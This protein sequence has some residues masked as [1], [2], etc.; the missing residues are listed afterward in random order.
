MWIALIIVAV[1]SLRETFKECDYVRVHSI[2]TKGGDAV[3]AVPDEVVIESYVRAGNPIA[4]KKVNEAVNRA[5]SATAASIGCSVTIT[6]MAGSEA[7]IEDGGLRN[8]ALE[9]FEELV[10][11]EGYFYTGEWCA[12]STDMGDISSLFPSIHMYTSGA[13][14]TAHG[15]DYI[16][17][18]P[19]KACVMGA[20]AELGLIIKLLENNA[21]RAKE[22][23]ANFKP[24]FNSVDEYL[25]HKRSINMNK[26]T[27][28]Y[29]EDGTITLDYKNN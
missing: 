29:N 22:V 15:K 23:I 1:N 6:D 18:D 3:N 5:I 27:V 19:Y 28:I 10:G 12:S 17:T 7:L 4:H 21:E 20:K 13:E 8:V 2:I 9:V 16:I 14:G 26:T 25:A 11:K 24:I